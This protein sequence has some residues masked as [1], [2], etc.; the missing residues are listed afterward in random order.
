M[1]VIYDPRGAPWNPC[2][3]HLFVWFFVTMEYL[4]C[5]IIY[6]GYITCS[7][8]PHASNMETNELWL[9]NT[10]LFIQWIW[11]QY[12]ILK[13]SNLVYWY[14][15]DSNF[16]ETILPWKLYYHFPKDNRSWIGPFSIIKKNQSKI[17]I[18]FCST[19]VHAQS[20]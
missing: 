17:K 18:R 9:S 4:Q 14:L 16:I 6:N 20:L 15:Y 8:T 2:C 12:G 7:H 1:T 11:Q 3:R 13:D 19:K 10:F 5:F